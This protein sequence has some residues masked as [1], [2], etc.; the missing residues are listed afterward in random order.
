MALLLVVVVFFGGGSLYGRRERLR[1]GFYEGRMV[2]VLRR[3]CRAGERGGGWRWRK[4]MRA[5]VRQRQPV[6]PRVRSGESLRQQPTTRPSSSF[7]PPSSL[8]ALAAT[9]V[10]RRSTAQEAH[11]RVTSRSHSPCRPPV[12]ALL[13]FLD[14][15][16]L[17]EG[18]SRRACDADATATPNKTGTGRRQREL[19]EAE[20]RGAHA[21]AAVRLPPPPSSPPPPTTTPPTP[22]H[23]Y[24]IK[25]HTH[26]F[27]SSSPSPPALPASHFA[28]HSYE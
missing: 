28:G 5:H 21:H 16:F 27:S 2:D 7:P 18:T 6:I 3:S 19:P 23:Q 4:R 14:W 25:T 11:S 12:P 24:N 13:P 10:D 9:A 22:S 15:L 8:M 20:G 17:C 1:G 26:S